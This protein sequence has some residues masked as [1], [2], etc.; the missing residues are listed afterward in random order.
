VGGKL[1]RRVGIEPYKADMTTTKPINQT[2]MLA[3]L[4]ASEA[5][6]DRQTRLIADK[7]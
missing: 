2:E 7:C 4:G 5:V 6:R 3:T 1:L